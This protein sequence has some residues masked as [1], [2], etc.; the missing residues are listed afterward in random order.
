MGKFVCLKCGSVGSELVF[1]KW[2]HSEEKVIIHDDG[3]IEYGVAEVDEE[4]ELGAMSGYKCGVCGH[5]LSL[6]GSHV[7]NESD[8]KYY[9]SMSDEDIVA[10]EELCYHDEDA[11]NADCC[12]PAELCYDE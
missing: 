11:D 10:M 4:N 1:E 5:Y 6:Y 2:V 12:D 8:L 3:H 9:L 7:D